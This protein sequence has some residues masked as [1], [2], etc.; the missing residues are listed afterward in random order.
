MEDENETEEQ[1]INELAEMRQQI[2]ELKTLVDDQKRAEKKL[3]KFKTVS[4]RAVYGVVI[5][6]FVGNLIYVNEAFAQM[7]GYAKEELIGRHFSIFY[8][9][10]QLRNVERLRDQI[11]QQGSYIAEELWH[12]RKNCTIFPTLITGAVIKDDKEKPLYLYATTIDLTERKQA[13][14]EIKKSR[15][16]FQMLACRLQ[17]IREEERTR[18]AREIHDE[19]GQRLTALKMDLSWLSRRLPQDQKSLFGKVDSMS[20]L[21]DETIHAVQRIST[22]L[23]PSI[24]DN[25]GLAAALEWQAREFQKRTGLICD[26]TIDPEDIIIDKDR[27]ITLFR[28]LQETLTN[29]ARHAHAKRIKISLKKEDGMGVLEVR[30]N[31]KGITPEQISDPKSLGLIGMRE[32]LR[33]WEGEINISGIRGKGTTVRVSI[34]L[35]EKEKLKEKEF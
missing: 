16:S 29:V 35:D 25:L 22:E 13:M 31:G 21:I 14:E 23:R 2:A 5:S 6:N 33:F 11:V 30:D 15:E 8:N 32:R 10:E 1:L 17:Y 18:I 3:R 12:K 4:D 27:S 34:P 28:I 19:L 26:F 7:H 24:L 20:G 9:E